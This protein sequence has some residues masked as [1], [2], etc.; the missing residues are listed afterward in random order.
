[1]HAE[2]HPL[3]LL[4]V[5]VQVQH[6]IGCPHMPIHAKCVSGFIATSAFITK[7]TVNNIGTAGN[8]SEVNR[9]TSVGNYSPS[10]KV[11]SNWNLRSCQSGHSHIPLPVSA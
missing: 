5:E 2:D 6:V 11:L 7:L 8:L 3:D 1:M 10:H 9:Q 4:T